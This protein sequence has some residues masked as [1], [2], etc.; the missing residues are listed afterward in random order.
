MRFL[1]KQLEMFL[2]GNGHD[3]LAKEISAMEDNNGWVNFKDVKEYIK[4]G[5][6]PSSF[7]Y[8]AARLI[9]AHEYK[10]YEVR[11]SVN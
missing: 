5:K 6:N 10:D 3:H 8:E 7:E 9:Q 1:K 2:Q 11:C 4:T